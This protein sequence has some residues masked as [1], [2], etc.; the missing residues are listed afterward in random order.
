MGNLAIREVG[1]GREFV[2]NEGW[3]TEGWRVVMKGTW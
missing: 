2:T 3:E 1:P